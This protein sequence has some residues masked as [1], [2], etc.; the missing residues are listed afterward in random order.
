MC[1][2]RGP[3][4]PKKEKVAGRQKTMHDEE[5]YNL[6]SSPSVIWRNK[7]RR[8]KLASSVAYIVEMSNE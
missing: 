5:I 8:M 7:S 1:V 4:A 2:L 3:A 6:C